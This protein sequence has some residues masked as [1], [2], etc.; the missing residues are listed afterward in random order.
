MHS[1]T[2]SHVYLFNN[3]YTLNA[4]NIL[5]EWSSKFLFPSKYISIVTVFLQNTY[6][7]ISLLFDLILVFP[8]NGINRTR[9][10]LD[11]GLHIDSPFELLFSGKP[12]ALILP[13]GG[14]EKGRVV[15]HAGRQQQLYC[16]FGGLPN[17]N[18][19]WL[20][21]EVVPGNFSQNASGWEVVRSRT[22]DWSDHIGVSRDDVLT[23]S[24]TRS[25]WFRCLASNERGEDHSDIK[26][27]VSGK[28][29]F[30]NIF[31]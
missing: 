20:Y 28:L 30:S 13:V 6:I 19:T 27:I 25:G 2:I 14:M 15:V 8:K 4:K 3:I 22:F 29:D 17:P 11:A 1:G 21:Q 23:T 9:I 12:S 10:L 24:E 7:F 18:V 5:S 26:Y 31:F 16:Q